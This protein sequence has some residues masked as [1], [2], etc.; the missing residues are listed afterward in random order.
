MHFVQAKGLLSAHNGMNL[1]RGCT[2]GCI[3]CDSRSRCYHIEHAFEDVEV[4]QNAPALL[5][6]ALSRKRRPCM[7]GTGSMCD[8]YLPLEMELGL[9]RKCLEIIESRGF[10]A[11]VLTKSDRVLRDTALLARVNERAKCVVQM[12]LTTLDPALCAVLEPNVC[13]TQARFAALMRLKAAGVPTVVWLGPLLPFLNDTEENLRGVLTLCLEAGV[14]G[15][16]CFGAGLTLRDGNREY[17]YEKL[18]AHFPGLK[19]RYQEKYGYAYEVTS[20]QNTRLM[21]IFHDLCEKRGVLHTPEQ[22]FSYLNEF[23]DREPR[24]F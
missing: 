5:E 17:F 15:V 9:T 10:G 19:R 4:K 13:N 20:Q 18:D 11:A 23:P 21:R 2:H 8:P 1:Y 12:T 14:R 22:V 7:I 6:D 16:L 24:L 3:Y